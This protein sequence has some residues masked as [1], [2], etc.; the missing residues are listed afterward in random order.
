ME[1]KV[2]EIEKQLF[3]LEQKALQLQMNP[4]FIFNSLNSIQ[5]YILKNDKTS[6]N[7]YLAKFSRLM[8]IILDNSQHQQIPI[9]EELNALSLYVELESLRFK[10]KF[11]YDRSDKDKY[12]DN[13][14][15][16]YK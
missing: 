11:E 12:Y 5:Y 1:K 10:E 15:F 6:S 7:R 9:Q 2:L 13:S 4:H 3:D 8:R 14:I 16:S